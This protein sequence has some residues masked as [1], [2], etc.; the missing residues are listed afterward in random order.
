VS[1]I[2]IATG[3]Q[4]HIAAWSAMRAALWPRLSRS[5][6]AAEL[7]RLLAEASGDFAASMAVAV[8]GG[9]VGFAEAALRRDYVNGCE[10]TPVAFL[11]GLFVEP[12]HRR[13]GVARMLVAA[14]EH[15]GRR[16][17]CVELASDALLDDCDSHAFHLG[18]GFEE[19]ERVV[20]YRKNLTFAGRES[21]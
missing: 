2:R 21:P 10:T 3:S 14:V 6:H 15:W 19:T 8:D 11:E 4:P 13:T 20:F 7:T 1:A 17:G 12:A 9:L 18:A 5:E 16:A